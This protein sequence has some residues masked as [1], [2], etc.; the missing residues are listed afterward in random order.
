MLD[1]K[2]TNIAYKS[3]GRH[4]AIMGHTTISQP[5][6]QA[7]DILLALTLQW[8]ASKILLGNIPLGPKSNNTIK[9]V[10]GN[11]GVTRKRVRVGVLL[12]CKLPDDGQ[13]KLSPTH[14]SNMEISSSYG[15]NTP[16][17]TST[18]NNVEDIHDRTTLIL[19][20]VI[21]ATGNIATGATSNLLQ[22]Q[23]KCHHNEKLLNQVIAT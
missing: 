13:G 1:K 19:P 21:I 20:P 15:N 12:P 11:I 5:T 23:N 8:Q 6:E 2:Q 18:I 10:A 14:N 16:I 9:P 4:S 17:P 3:S 7:Q 22:K